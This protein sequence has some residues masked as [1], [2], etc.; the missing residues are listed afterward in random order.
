MT[1][2]YGPLTQAAVERLQC[3]MG[4]V[5]GGTVATTGYGRFGPRTLAVLNASSGI[6]GAD[7]ES[8]PIMSSEAVATTST[9]ATITWTTNEPAHSRVMWSTSFPF[10][11]ASAPFVADAN[12]DTTQVVSINGLLPGTTYFYVREST[13]IQGNVMLTTVKTFRTN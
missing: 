7:D 8:A 2:F 6:G 10:I 3:R 5:C 1:G 11:Y 13:D 12:M 9:G 4:I